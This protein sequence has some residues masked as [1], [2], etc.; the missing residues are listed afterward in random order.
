MNASPDLP[1]DANGAVLRRMVEGGDSLAHP[2]V[3]EF[4]IIFARRQQAVAFVELVGEPDLELCISY[5]KE[6]EMWQTIVKRYMIPTHHE[7]SDCERI[8]TTRAKSV[9]GEA[10]GWGCLRITE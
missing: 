7:I 10:D 6:R 9:G 8:L 5:Y 4:C 3:V 2:R 1:N